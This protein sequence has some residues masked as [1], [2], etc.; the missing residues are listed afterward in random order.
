MSISVIILMIILLI[1]AAIILPFTRDMMKDKVELAQNPINEKFKTLI[2]HINEGLMNGN[3]ELTLFDDD[4]KL[5]NLLDP[6]HPNMIVRFWYTTGSLTIELG[7]K[8]YQKE[9]TMKKQ[10]HGLRNVTLFQQKDIAY[11]FVKQAQQTISSHRQTIDREGLNLK[12]V[13]GENNLD[14]DD[15]PSAVLNQVYA[16]LSLEQKYSVAGLLY[17]I[18][19]AD[20][21][22]EYAATHNPFM[23]QMLSSLRVNWKEAKSYLDKNGERVVINNLKGVE[24]SILSQIA[25]SALPLCVDA[26]NGNPVESPIKQNKFFQCFEVLGYS[27]DEIEQDL[28]KMMLLAQHFGL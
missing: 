6:N 4:P 24:R 18:G 22:S 16:N 17:I 26:N 23:S 11:D 21:S 9:V 25:F 12:T 14:L 13:L 3:G 5:A 7:Y 1:L 2:A 28:Q 27:Q 15:D 19:N 20:G 8:Y 10:Y